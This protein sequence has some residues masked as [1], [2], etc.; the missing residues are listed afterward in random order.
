M[1]LPWTGETHQGESTIDGKNVKNAA[2][3]PN[4]PNVERGRVPT[5][6]STRIFFFFRFAGDALA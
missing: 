3:V 2:N 4:V 5:F 1:G 6:P